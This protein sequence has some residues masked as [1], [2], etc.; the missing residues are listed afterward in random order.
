MFQIHPI[1]VPSRA[2]VVRVNQFVREHVFISVLVRI[3]LR[4]SLSLSRH[5]STDDLL[6]TLLDVEESLID[7]APGLL[8]LFEQ[9][10]NRRVTKG[11]IF[12]SRTRIFPA[13]FIYAH[14]HTR[15][16]CRSIAKHQ[17]TRIGKTSL[18]LSLSRR[19]NNNNNNNE[20]KYIY[21]RIRC[22]PLFFFSPPPRRVLLEG[23]FRFG[24]RD[25][26]NDDEEEEEEE[27]GGRFFFVSLFFFFFFFFFFRSLF[28]SPF[29]FP[30]A[31]FFAAPPPPFFGLHLRSNLPHSPQK[32][33]T[34]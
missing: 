6:V 23:F 13:S 3:W 12:Q 10:P 17:K 31:P 26:V 5:E 34:F 30:S 2:I 21:R 22:P 25:D 14:T 28:F 27:R 20:K 19:D 24:E 4:T 32:K 7:G 15:A 1:H 18:C 29:F 16:R 9:E 33:K 11:D 8:E